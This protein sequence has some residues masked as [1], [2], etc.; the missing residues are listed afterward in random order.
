MES[1]TEQSVVIGHMVI[2]ISA[3]RE[4]K[5]VYHQ[6][7]YA[8]LRKLLKLRWY[9]KSEQNKVIRKIHEDL[10]GLTS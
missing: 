4:Y 2:H 9:S 1:Q 3:Y 6:K 7:G 10:E 8:G 5:K